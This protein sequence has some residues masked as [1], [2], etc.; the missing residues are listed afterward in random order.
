MM[1]SYAQNLEDVLLARAF[2]GR[3][4]GFYIDVGAMHPTADS[5]TRHFYELGW[6]GI[7]VEPV[8]QH[9]RVLQQERPRDLNLR[10][11]LGERPGT[12]RIARVGTSGLSSLDA[13]AVESARAAGRAVDYEDVPMSTLAEICR[14]HVGGEIDFLK[15]DVEGWEEPVIRGGDWE[16]YRP[17]VVVVEATRPGSPLPS[18]A[19]WEPLLLA[20]D[21][22]FAW[23]DGLNR[24]YVRGESQELLSCFDSPPNVFDGFVT[25]RLWRAERRVERLRQKVRALK[26]RRLWGLGRL[27][28]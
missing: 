6:S 8:E 23:F 22:R 17:Q 9:W 26:G 1:I 27:L 10:I 12:A 13:A 25:Y 3:A 15:I 18:F 19:G 16:T 24:F 7:N 11:V 4:H 21:Y 28:K 2:Q 14:R 5:V 20:A